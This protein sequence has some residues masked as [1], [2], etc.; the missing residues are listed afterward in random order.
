MKKMII[1]LLALVSLSAFAQNH[2]NENYFNGGDSY[3]GQLDGRNLTLNLVS[4][5]NVTVGSFW[6]G[7][8]ADGQRIDV[9]SVIFECKRL[10]ELYLITCGAT[11]L[12]NDVF[13]PVRLDIIKGRSVTVTLEDGSQFTLRKKNNL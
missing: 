7:L 13:V 9:D 1:G 2:G 6:T 10:E 5:K 12:R 8:P 11:F 3:T 4:G